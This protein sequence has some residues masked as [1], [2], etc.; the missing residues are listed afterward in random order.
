MPFR[1]AETRLT[2]RNGT[3]SVPYKSSRPT[4]TATAWPAVPQLTVMALV[5]REGR[6]SRQTTATGQAGSASS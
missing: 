3:E 6:G 5:A 4:T 2:P 1:E